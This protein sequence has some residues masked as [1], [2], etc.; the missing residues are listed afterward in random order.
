MSGKPHGKKVI[1]KKKKVKK[2]EPIIIPP[3]I[4]EAEPQDFN[5]FQLGPKL[6]RGAFGCVYQ[7]LNKDT[8]DYVA[9]KT[10]SL[11]RFPDAL[12]SVQQEIDLM[13][14]LEHP[15]VVKYI[16]S[17][18]TKDFLY[19]VMEFAEGGSLQNVQ[20]K[21]ENFNEHLASKYLYEVL[22]G[23]KY[24]HEQSIIHRDI[25][26]ANILLTKGHCKLSDF[27]ISVKLTDN[28]NPDALSQCSPFWA[29]PEVI[30]MEPITEKCD[31]WSL[32]ITAIELFA[33]QPPYF[34]LNAVRAM[35]QIVQNPE[36]PL[37]K[38][39]SANFKDFLTSCLTKN[40]TFRKN[41]EQLLK[42]PFI[43]EHNDLMGEQKI[44]GKL[45]RF[46]EDT[47]LQEDIFMSTNVNLKKASEGTSNF[48]LGDEEPEES[49]LLAGGKSGGP[50]SL[51]SFAEDESG[52][53]DFL[54]LPPADP[55][56]QINRLK[57]LENPPQRNRTLSLFKEGS[58]DFDDLD[59]SKPIKLESKSSKQRSLSSFQE[60]DDNFN[61]IMDIN[62]ADAKKNM[63]S[64]KPRPSLST[65]TEKDD[66]DDQTFNLKKPRTS[67]SSFK[68]DDDD[69]FADLKPSQ[70]QQRPSAIKPKPAANDLS[71]FQE[72]D[73][74][75]FADLK[76]ATPKIQQPQPVCLQPKPA[77]SGLDK[78]KDDDDDDF[79]DLKPAA[80]A[81]KP[82]RKIKPQPLLSKFAEDDDDDFGDLKLASPTLTKIRTS[83][84][85]TIA[86]SDGKPFS[87]KKKPMFNIQDNGPRKPSESGLKPLPGKS[88]GGGGG[89]HIQ[90]KQGGLQIQ[91]KSGGLQIQ[92]KS[93]GLQI[94]PTLQ[95][96]G[97]NQ[98]KPKANIDDLFTG[99]FSAAEDNA[100]QKESELMDTILNDL[101]GLIQYADQFRAS[102]NDDDEDEA[103]LKTLES[104]E[105]LIAMTKRRPNEICAEIIKILHENAK[106]RAN[107]GI[108]HGI[109]PILSVVQCDVP[110]ILEH[111][112]P[113]VIEVVKDQPTL[114]RS[115]C[116]M[117]LVPPLLRYAEDWV[118]EKRFYGPNVQMN[119]LK[120]ISY[121]CALGCNIDYHL[122]QLF[123]SAGG[124]VG[125]TNIFR[126]NRHSERPELTPIL[127]GCVRYVF[128]APMSTSKSALSRIFSQAGLIDLLAERYA[129]IDANSE[130]MPY[131]AELFVTFS[132]AD[133]VVRLNMATP[134]F[135]DAI[136]TKAEKVAGH[137]N[138]LSDEVL[139]MLTRA[140]NN[141]TMDQ[142][143][144]KALWST[145][146][147]DK[148]LNYLRVDKAEVSMTQLVSNC[149]SALFNMTRCMTH[150][151]ASQIAPLIPMLVYIIKHQSLLTELA[152]TVFLDLIKTHSSDSKVR[153]RLSTYNALGVLYSL[154]HT[155]NH[156]DQV[157]NGFETW[158][159]QKPQQIQEEL[160]K[161][162]D[163][164][165]ICAELITTSVGTTMQADCA[166]KIL[167]I[168]EKCPDLAISMST[169]EFVGTVMK[170]LR[171]KVFRS[172]PE[173][174]LST[175]NILALFVDVNPSPK[176]FFATYRVDEIAQKYRTGSIDTVKEVAMRLVRSL[177]SNYIL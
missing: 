53:D 11:T 97:N 138:K 73:D 89:L 174:L 70:P 167:S 87:P 39:I 66:D 24:L 173:I 144:A 131:I 65:F 18:Q 83:D 75:D 165:A 22:L 125:L 119:A 85:P 49:P 172:H 57:N 58:S 166:A 158:A 8:G 113:V 79:G 45:G 84:K 134:K 51:A 44:E 37:P 111:A 63:E 136:F 13:A 62:L 88:S 135:I 3:P 93:G 170:V 28:K 103:T 21:F 105:N 142:Q 38:D 17:H 108:R 132:E 112:I 149:F 41:T 78:F 25:K 163:F 69:D 54:D 12:D 31:I 159:L 101:D 162:A 128:K 117:G 99:I 115:F 96:M 124:L 106:L 160:M 110:E 107:L 6:G 47:D 72:D 50:T 100:V 23:L 139:I 10:I 2:E 98:H 42:H 148:L 147:C 94:Q 67:L 40:V 60:K 169:S 68:E 26:A 164:P 109:I 152:K 161:H 133:S 102:H 123:V 129:D 137:D 155:H 1:K 126:R 77:A 140:I 80:A 81:P 55:E 59:S 34:E 151:E 76:P 56:S 29:A 168:L 146:L 71:K 52:D 121:I 141:I 7:G 118:D 61:D 19:I 48:S 9:I 127:I 43:L 175:F 150:K 91:P 153:Q 14:P 33:G 143:V 86:I 120:M 16:T 154:F 82:A 104:S 4:I 27:G 116:I 95:I 145:T 46:Q 20:K 171:G 157:L 130:T 156:K 35:F 176:A 122:L 5:E 15:N 114:M 177:S 90:P 30:S 32:G 74:D 64:H 36:P 92:P